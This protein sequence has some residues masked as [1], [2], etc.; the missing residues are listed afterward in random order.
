MIV[1]AQKIISPN[2]GRIFQARKASFSLS[3]VG[4]LYSS[5]GCIIR[6]ADIVSVRRDRDFGVL[7]VRMALCY[8][9]HPAGPLLTMRRLI[10]VDILHAQTA[11]DR[12]KRL[13]RHVFE[14][15]RLMLQRDASEL[16]LAA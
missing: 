1:T 15:A 13:F 11:Q 8:Q 16:A 3:G 14:M 5:K 7:E 4:C 10:V 6:Q 9:T 12:R 2:F